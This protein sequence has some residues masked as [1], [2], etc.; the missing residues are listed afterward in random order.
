MDE[1]GSMAG[2]KDSAAGNTPPSAP[3]S[4]TLKVTAFYYLDYPDGPPADPLNAATMM[5]VEVGDE[6]SSLN[7]FLYTYAIQVYTLRYIELAFQSGQHELF[8]RAVLIVPELTNSVI[9]DFL[10][11]N[12]NRLEEW[13][14]TRGFIG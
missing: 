6:H 13:A 10:D 4:R 2:G 8:G 7:N 5:Y 11:A 1:S 14:D 12:I 9:S 3:P